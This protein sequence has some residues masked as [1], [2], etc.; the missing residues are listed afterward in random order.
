METHL[1]VLPTLRTLAIEFILHQ[2]TKMPHFLKNSKLIQHIF[3]NPHF[4]NLESE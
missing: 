3:Q 4:G 1:I 2:V